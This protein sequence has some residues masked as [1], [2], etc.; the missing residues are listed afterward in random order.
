[1]SSIKQVV[2]VHYSIPPV[3]GGVEFMLEPMAE[4]FAKN[5]WYVSM[6][7]GIGKINSKNIKTTIIPEL[8]AGNPSINNIQKMLTVGSLPDNYELN[9]HNFE[10]K[11]ETQI[12]DINDVIIHNLMT[13]P[14]N[15]IA[16]EAFFNYIENNPQK[17]FYV[18]I[19]DMAWL[20]EEHNKFLFERKPWSILKT[21]QKNVKYYTISKFR[22]RQATELMKIPPKQ[23]KVVPNGIDISKYL[24]LKESTKSILKHIDFSEV[25]NFVLIPARLIKRK[26]LERCIKI[27]AELKTYDPNILAIIAGS[28]V[29]HS[30]ESQNYYQSLKDLAVEKEAEKNIR[31]LHELCEIENFSGVENREIVHDL[32]FISSFVML[33]S[34]DEGFGLPLLEAGVTRQPL[35]LSDLE[36]FREIAGKNAVYISQMEPEKIAAKTIKEEILDNPTLTQN[37]FQE[38]F[39]KYTWDAVWEAYLSKDFE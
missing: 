33:L 24:N 32:Y 10:K 2:I 12:G 30:D 9:V 17:N 26:N 36:V 3:V 15:L 35:V 22:K 29:A 25:S 7:T 23:I 4:L 13:M 37:M 20:M 27:I 21:A 1:M 39:R 19:H 16:T 38:V 28:P 6:L 18:W 8:Y 31:F 14:F 5:G 11:I 34:T